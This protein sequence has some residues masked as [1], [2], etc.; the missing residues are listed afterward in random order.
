MATFHSPW[1]NDSTTFEATDMNAALEQ[2]D[3]RLVELALAI[4]DIGGSFENVPVGSEVILRFPL[5]RD[6]S[7][8]DNME[9]S[10]I[11][12]GIPATAESIISFRKNNAEFATATFSAGGT[13]GIM[14]GSLTD[15]IAGDILTIVCP[16]VADSTLG[17]LGWCLAGT[18]VVLVP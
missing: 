5:P 17:N 2:L 1:V 6:I 13:E 18:R 3:E 4:Y 8:A 14:L 16:S 15:F 7:F 9:N 11:V 12:A 10:R